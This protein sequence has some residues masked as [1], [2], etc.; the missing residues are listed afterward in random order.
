[1]VVFF[2]F[3]VLQC[4]SIYK[5]LNKLHLQNFGI[6]VFS[7]VEKLALLSLFTLCLGHKL[8]KCQDNICVQ[9]KFS[10]CT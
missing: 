10:K 4:N 9:I 1:M 2:L 6:V 3:S 8:Q 5:Q 7:L